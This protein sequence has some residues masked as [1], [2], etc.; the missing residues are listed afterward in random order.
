[1]IAAA[2]RLLQLPRQILYRYY[3]RIVINTRNF[4]SPTLERAEEQTILPPAS[5]SLQIEG[6]ESEESG[7]EQFDGLVEED[8]E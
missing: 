5:N 6:T 7:T 3:R 8:A 2:V 1:M 4:S